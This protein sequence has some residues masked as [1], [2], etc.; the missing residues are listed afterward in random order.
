MTPLIYLWEQTNRGEGTRLS[1]NTKVHGPL[2]RVFGDDAVVSDEDSL[3]SPAPGINLADGNPTRVFPDMAQ[4]LAGNTNAATG[5]CPSRGHA[6]Q[7]AA[8]RH[9]ARLLLRVPADGRLPRQLRRRRP[10][11]DASAS[12]PA[13]C[14]PN[15]GGV[16][17]DEVALTVDQTAGPF[18]VTSQAAAG[19]TVAGGSSVPVTWAVNNT[20]APGA[21]REDLAV[22]R[23][24]RDV[25]HGARRGDA[26]RRVARR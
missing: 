1:D 20:A 25:R 15:G 11:D 24:R 16:A 2:F 4:V 22:H 21:E 26:Q 17:Y 9:A 13:T 6:A 10:R 12:P 23:R 14:F 19:S 5:T 7:P 3:K 8:A 18:L